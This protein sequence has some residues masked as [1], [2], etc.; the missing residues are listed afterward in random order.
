MRLLEIVR[1]STDVLQAVYEDQRAY[2]SDRGVQ[3]VTVHVE[4]MKKADRHTLL[5]RTLSAPF[6]VVLIRGIESLREVASLKPRARICLDAV[7]NSDVGDE[8]RLD[9]WK[10]HRV[11][12][13]SKSFVAALPEGMQKSSKIVL[14]GGPY[15]PRGLSIPHP[16]KAET[17]F[18]LLD[19]YSGAHKVLQNILFTQKQTGWEGQ[20][21]TTLRHKS[22]LVQ[23]VSDHYEVAEMSNVLLAP[24]ETEE[25]GLPSEGAILAMSFDRGLISTQIGALHSTPYNSENYLIV[26]KYRPGAWGRA[27]AV[28]NRGRTKYE[29]FPGIARYNEQEASIA[30]LS[31]MSQCQ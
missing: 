2:W 15:L 30:L 1:H 16:G 8:S 26:P 17:H 20:I 12:C 31:G 25:H 29:A 18:G 10:L 3:I 7:S 28:Y 22:P 9:L 4:K 11:F 19:L 6:D 24:F 21:V 23:T 13:Y 14:M 5:R 27:M